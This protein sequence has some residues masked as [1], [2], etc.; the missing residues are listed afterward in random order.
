MPPA[1]TLPPPASDQGAP[2]DVAL[3]Q[4]ITPTLERLQVAVAGIRG[5][6]VA[7][8]DGRPL[9]AVLPQHDQDS[10]AAVV[11]AS[12][13]L[14]HRLADLTGHGDLQEL[15]VRS[16]SGYVVIYALGDRGV[17]TVLT[18]RASNLALIHL[19]AREA[20]NELAHTVDRA[21]EAERRSPVVED[22]GP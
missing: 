17:L 22:S 8:V 12:L 20:V 1:R 11:A 18:T 16:A 9:A 6:L 15:V 7:S 13:G 10:T 2:T 19:K 14:S 21:M 3:A 5:V 4:A